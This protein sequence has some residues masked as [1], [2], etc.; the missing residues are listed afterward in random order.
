MDRGIV[1][2]SDGRYVATPETKLA[3]LRT[4][5]DSL[6]A[7]LLEIVDARIQICA[8]VAELKKVYS[9]PMMQPGRMRIVHERAQEFARSH[10]LSGDFIRS[11]YELLIGEACRVEDLIIDAADQVECMSPARPRGSSG[12]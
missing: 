9:I 4:E 1:Q 6:D 7:R 12:R 5:L 10:G 11:L 3:E 2:V 8:E